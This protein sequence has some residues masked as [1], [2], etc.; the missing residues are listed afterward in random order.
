[1]A[2]RG[3]AL[4]AG[5][6]ALATL[7]LAYPLS[8]HPARLG[9]FDN[10]DARLNAWVISW[11]SHQLGADPLRLFEANIFHPLPH[12]LAFSEHLLIPGLLAMPL[13]SAT[14]DLVLT[15][16]LITLTAIFTSAL[17]MYVLVASLSGS[18]AAALVSGLAFAFTPYRFDQLP[19]LQMQLYAFLPLALA[20]L[21]RFLATG[22]TR[23]ALGFAG[24]FVI[25]ALSGTYLAAMAA[26]AVAVVM[27]TLAPASWRSWYRGAAGL[28]PAGLLSAAAI[29]PFARPY[30][31]VHRTLGIEWDLPGIGSMSA[32]PRSYLWSSSHL[33]R[34]LSSRLV[35]EADQT[36]SLFPGLL[37]LIL[38][39]A[40]LLLLLS[41]KGS[42]AR[43]RA[44][45]LCYFLIAGVG[46]LISLGPGSPLQPL[47]YD[48]VIFFRG[49][50][51]LWRFGLL[52]LLGS[53]VLAGYAMAYLFEK[54]NSGRRRAGA[55]ALLALASVAE[56]T[57]VPYGL[58]SFRDEPP[59]VYAWLAEQEPGPIV[60]L[61]FRVI[62]TRY[63]FWARHHG[64]RPMLNG[65][66]GFIPPSHQWMQILFRRFPSAD[67]L[68]LLQQLRV[69]YLIVHLGAYRPSMLLRL[70]NGLEGYRNQLVPVRDFGRDL[71][72]EVL[73]STA[74]EARPDPGEK[75]PARGEPRQWFDG[76]REKT[77]PA[78]ETTTVIE[79]QLERETAIAGI[80]F[81]YGREP[82][83]P[84]E[85]VEVE[86]LDSQGA[87]RT[88]WTTPAEEPGLT[89]MVLGLASE[90][91]HGTQT[92]GFP[93]L[94]AQRLRL[95]LRGLDAPPEIAEVEPL[96]PY[97]N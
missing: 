7:A 66:S 55:V 41:G 48:Q 17:A 72:F 89:E 83:V 47:L 40:G 77:W 1:L 19:H 63:M 84:L 85:R 36:S 52:P 23:W 33:Y 14:N 38:A 68:R 44:H 82:R 45:A 35:P 12:T 86:I 42:F 80:R 95:K 32:T 28:L 22:R 21:D 81:H 94:P 74:A 37:V 87:W 10:G 6:Y 91:P 73:P 64:F 60:E 39:V 15:Y 69:R 8:F 27:L 78:A 51:A 61:P 4:A 70:L 29:L 16:N 57:G 34:D 20:A 56:S 18:Q 67:A 62:D 76:E 31:W 43:P 49:L 30:L 5:F 25:Q 88:A 54:L 11:V 96:A 2:W 24:C 53:T 58:E 75:V 13:L 3:L 79:L 90:P 9:R 92:V 26:V 50:R 59:P 71:V 65:D 93:P 46:F 97:G